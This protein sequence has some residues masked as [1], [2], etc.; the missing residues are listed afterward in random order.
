L[1]WLAADD[2]GDRSVR[3]LALDRLLEFAPY[4]IDAVRMRLRLLVAESR[5]GDARR[6]YAEWKA[7]YRTAVG[8]DPPEVWDGAGLGGAEVVPDL[9]QVEAYAG[10]ASKRVSRAPSP[11]NGVTDPNV[12]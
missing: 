11:G 5:I 1:R 6:D 2:L 12:P 7:R 10:A 9:L 8:T 3:R 4:D